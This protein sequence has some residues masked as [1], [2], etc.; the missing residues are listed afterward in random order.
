[1][2]RDWA[3]PAGWGAGVFAAA[4]TVLLAVVGFSGP[5]AARDG[6]EILMFV[7]LAAGPGLLLLSL[8]LS[9][10][11]RRLRE[12]RSRGATLA[13]GALVGGLV[14]PLADLVV[15]LFFFG[16]QI[17]TVFL[18]PF[19]PESLLTIGMGV[20]GGATTGLTCAWRVTAGR[21]EAA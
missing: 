19:H 15:P 12:G 4:T 13:L 10:R 14:G 6:M 7:V 17:L 5:G 9:A 21:E 20:I 11:L 8:Y 18:L 3:M 1:M 2:K 16:P